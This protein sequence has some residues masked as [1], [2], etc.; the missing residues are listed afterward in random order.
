[1]SPARLLVLVALL[2]VLGQLFSD[3]GSVKH[4]I[5]K[6]VQRG[7]ALVASS[8][9]DPS[10][11]KAEEGLNARFGHVGSYP[12]VTEATLRDDPELNWG[13]GVTV[14]WCQPR[15]VVLSAMT[16][17][18]TVSRLLLDGETVGDVPGSVTCPLDLAN[19]V[20]WETA[21]PG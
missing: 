17:K 14:I 8:T 13:V 21:N 10:L 19:P 5:D 2:V 18:G 7:Q 1:M 11:R 6:A 20:P 9:E 3:P 4:W 15:A 16:G 12:V